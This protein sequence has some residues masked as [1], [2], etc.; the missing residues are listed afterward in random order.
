MT[1][2]QVLPSAVETGDVGGGPRVQYLANFSGIR[3]M[4]YNGGEYV[5]VYANPVSIQADGAGGYTAIVLF[6]A[7]PTRLWG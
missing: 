2:V 7:N 3:G 5:V 6:Q 1:V 4:G